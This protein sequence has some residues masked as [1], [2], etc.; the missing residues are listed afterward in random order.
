MSEHPL[1]QD[2]IDFDA[3]PGTGDSAVLLRAMQF[4][5]RYQLGAQSMPQAPNIDELRKM[6]PILEG[7]VKALVVCAAGD[8]ELDD[9]ERAWIV[10][11]CANAGGTFELVEELRTLNPSDVN[12]MQLM[13]MTERP[14]LFTHALIYNAIQASDAD[15]V[16]DERELATIQMMAGALGVSR[17][18]VDELVA[19]YEEE[20][21][22]FARKMAK[23]FPNGHPWG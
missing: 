8:G 6:L 9:A 22:F 23:L 19:L 20:K 12:V 1:L 11:F 10:G 4:F 14:G 3:P 7:Y 18:Y 17:D 5:L 16:L 13:Q 2:T 21:A 15:G